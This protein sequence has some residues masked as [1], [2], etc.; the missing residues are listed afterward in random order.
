MRICVAQTRPIKGDIP[1]NIAGHKKL[2][3][4]ALVERAEI[5]VFPELSITGYEPTLAEELATGSDDRRFDDFQQ[6]AD[7][8]QI[9]IGIGVPLRSDVGVWIS[10]VLFQPHTARQTYSK[11]HLHA[12]EEGFFV[13]GQSSLGL[14][15]DRIAIAI[16]YELSVP[17]HA[18][19]AHARGAE[20]YL[21]SVA[22]TV[23]GVEKAIER[24]SDIAGE[25][26]MT[27]LMANC[28]GPCDGAMCGGK[29]SIWDNNGKLV[30]QLN[31]RD[32][33]I[34]VIDTDTQETIE[35]TI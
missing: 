3:D 5:V 25:Y 27:V 9:T 23:P 24:L 34:V 14:L 1:A 33:G 29:S 16:C 20:I 13:S 30:G 19:N 18:E 17:Q 26:C 11:K 15:G 21:A 28:V 8:R 4:L 2:I 12:D 22:K 31:E 7:A 6:I 35:M 32:E 10:M